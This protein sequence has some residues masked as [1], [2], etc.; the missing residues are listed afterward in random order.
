MHSLY[1]MSTNSG[2]GCVAHKGAACTSGVSR[3]QC[4]TKDS[5]PSNIVFEY[6]SSTTYFDLK[7]VRAKNR[8]FLSGRGQLVIREVVPMLGV[9]GVFSRYELRQDAGGRREGYGVTGRASAHGGASFFRHTA[10]HMCSTV[11]VPPS[12]R[13]RAA[14]PPPPHTHLIIFGL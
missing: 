12:E 5:M 2:G 3:G 6:I 10:T 9:E 4:H 14:P 8:A 13:R 1:G 11:H 7:E